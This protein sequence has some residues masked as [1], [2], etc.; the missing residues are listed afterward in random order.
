MKRFSLSPRRLK[1]MIGKEFVQVR[2]DTSVIIMI[3]LV[4]FIQLIIFGYA[5]NTTPR[6]MALA[7][8]DLDRSGVSAQVISG[9][10]ASGYFKLTDHL[11]TESESSLALR[12]GKAKFILTI[13][14]NFGRDFHNGHNPGLL[15]QADATDPVATSGVLGAIPGIE[16]NIIRELTPEYKRM[17]VPLHTIVH[18]QYNP[19]GNSQLNIVPGL[20]GAILIMSL[21]M[22]TSMSM[23]KER[24]YGTLEM[25]L[26]TPLSPLEVMVGKIIPFIIV[27]YLQ[28]A[29]IITMA[30]F[31]FA[32]PIKGSLS[33]LLLLSLPFIIANLCV[34]ITVSTFAKTQ[35]EAANTGVVYFLP[36]LLLSGFLFPFSGM[37]HWAQVI[38]N[39]LP[40]THYVNI[41]RAIML[42]GTELSAL[43]QDTW[44]ML[45]FMGT[46]ILIAV[47]RYRTTLDD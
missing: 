18:R 4:P 17:P 37:P 23:T 30:V 28:I 34:G 45:V 15:L 33:D 36:S 21:V 13:P 38:G 3:V 43:W 41:C 42:K 25:L 29:V 2:R 16:G 40:L 44:P 39:I 6:D 8:V 20:I 24:E 46:L 47:L 26:A 31:M 19:Q 27:G 1:A 7:V 9:Y 32:V 14:E 12:S 35:L 10:K 22:T 5:I 11:W